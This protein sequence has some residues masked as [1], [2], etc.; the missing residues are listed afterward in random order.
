MTRL[1]TLI[2]AS[3]ILSTNI[4]GQYK[5][6]IGRKGLNL[7][8][9]IDIAIT[10]DSDTL[11]YEL[12]NHW[13]T[14]SFEELKQ[15]IIPLKDIKMY[16]ST[17]DSITI[18]LNE[19]YVYLVDKKYGISQKI[20]NNKSSVS[21]ERMRKISYAHKIAKENGLRHF[22]LYIFEDLKLN[23]SEFRKKAE[24]N[25]KAIIKAEQNKRK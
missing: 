19:E 9:H 20:K 6:Y 14:D 5:T 4:Y 25:L 11:R 23:E 18:D 22:D 21:V 1:F 2:L 16:D 15:I 13:Y 8:G 17:N 10:I 7:P 24:A 3:F 12:F